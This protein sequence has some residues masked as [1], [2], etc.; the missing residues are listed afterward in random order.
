L[1][2]LA[3]RRF[4]GVVLKIDGDLAAEARAQGCP[5]CGGRL[6]SAVFPRKPR[7]GPDGLSAEHEKRLSF[8]CA[9][10]GCRRRTTPLSVRFLGRK[11]Y[12]GGVVVLATAMQSGITPARAAKLKELFGAS[13]RT[14]ARWRTWWRETFTESAFWKAG[15]A[16]LI[17]PVVESE[18]PL[19]LLERFG[20]DGQVRLIAM[21]RFIAPITTTSPSGAMAF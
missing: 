7:G 16:R 2:P 9:H 6:H 18:M 5:Y 10:E 21:L 1:H 19:S 15:K 8:C 17:P 4:H 13:L 3:D 20:E 11:V 12:L 14:L